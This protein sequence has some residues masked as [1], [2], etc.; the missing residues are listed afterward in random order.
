MKKTEAA[1][2]FETSYT[3]ACIH[4]RPDQ[5]QLGQWPHLNQPRIGVWMYVFPAHCHTCGW[6]MKY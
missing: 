2:M 3:H 6:P 1:N 4:R 5:L